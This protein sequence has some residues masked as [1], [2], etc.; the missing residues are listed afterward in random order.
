MD[1]FRILYIDMDSFYASVE[2]ELNPELRGEQAGITAADSDAG[3]IVAASCG[4]KAPGIGVGTRIG[5]AERI[6]PGIALVGARQWVA[7]G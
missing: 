3:A 7:R 2:R 4:A 5:D 6:R 1:V